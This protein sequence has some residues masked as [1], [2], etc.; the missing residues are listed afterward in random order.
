MILWIVEGDSHMS[1]HRSNL[2]FFHHGAF[3]LHEGI[4]L[5]G[6]LARCKRFL[7]RLEGIFRLGSPR[8]M[9]DSHVLNQIEPLLASYN[10]SAES[11]LHSFEDAASGHIP[12]RNHRARPVLNNDAESDV[13]DEV[14]E[15]DG[16]EGRC[17][18]T[19]DA[20]SKAGYALQNKLI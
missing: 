1:C 13:A 8:L 15:T 18:G 4:S 17:Q 11:L 16:S 2:Y 9:N 6:T 12:S 14:R 20:L 19:A 3:S 10:G 7:M 5:Q